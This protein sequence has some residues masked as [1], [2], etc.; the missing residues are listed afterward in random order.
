MDERAPALVAD[1]ANCVGLCCV[2]L[3][4][5]R[6]EDF[7]FSKD[8]ADPCRNLSVDYRCVVHSALRSSGLKGCTV[9]DCHGAGQK[10]TRSVYGGA[11]W[12]DSLE[13]ATE[14]FAVFRVVRQLHEILWYLA[15]AAHAI[16]QGDLHERLETEYEHIEWMSE[17][18][19]E[20]IVSVD[21]D[22]LRAGANILLSEASQR[23]RESA[24]TLSPLALPANIRSGA[25]LL[26]ASLGGRDL[27]GADLR[28][29]LL[30]AADLGLSDLRGADLLAAD[31]RDANL[32]GADLSSALF[33]TQMQ[34]NAS[35]GD[36]STRIP[37]GTVRPAHWA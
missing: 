31:L 13:L 36:G 1:C 19:G 35:Q 4:F 21:L 8:A 32:A 11:S 22:A 5:A 17:Q 24:R 16:P 37:W 18:T 7:A 26:G 20:Q 15:A 33:V 30:I 10:V 12:R 29:A 3:A 27:R 14:M 9:F 23:V 2:A 28:G 6:S 25:D 34:L